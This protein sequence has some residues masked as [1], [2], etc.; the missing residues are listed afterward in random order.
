MQKM[1]KEF[2]DDMK[3]GRDH[4]S[5]F[6]DKYPNQWVAIVNKKV[7]SHNS[8]LSK[9]EEIAKYKTHRKTIPTLFIDT[10]EHIYGN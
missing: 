6:L 4:R 7:V 5:E 1:P 3:C 10:G 8:N 2:C 9:V